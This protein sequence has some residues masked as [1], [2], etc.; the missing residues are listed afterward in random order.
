[1]QEVQKKPE[2]MKKIGTVR[3]IGG[4]VFIQFDKGK[5]KR[6]GS[7]IHA[8]VKEAAEGAVF[9][10]L[11]LFMLMVAVEANA[12][13]A[14]T[15][16]PQEYIQYCEEIGQA[17]HICPELLEAVIETES[18]GDPDAVGELGEIGLMQI[19]PKYHMDR[20]ERLGV[21]Y[22]F[23]PKGNILVGAD[24]LAEMFEEYRDTGTVLMVYNGTEDAAERGRRSDYTGYAEKVMKRAEQLERLHKK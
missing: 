12:Y 4:I 11:V 7:R 1:M 16:L 18:N 23:D 13:G 9:G 17:Y 3:E 14:D 6:S 8:A 5:K 24:Y 10:L 19:Y 22:L 15:E 20:A 2:K 21:R